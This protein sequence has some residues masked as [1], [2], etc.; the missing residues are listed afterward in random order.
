MQRSDFVHVDLRNSGPV[1]VLFNPLKFG[2]LISFY[3]AVLA[4]S[5]INYRALISGIAFLG[6]VGVVWRKVSIDFFAMRRALIISLSIVVIIATMRP[7]QLVYLSWYFVLLILLQ[8]GCGSVPIV[9]HGKWRRSRLMDFICTVHLLILIFS[10]FIYFTG[11][12][13]FINPNASAALI[14][15]LLLV[16]VLEHRE[17]SLFNK[18]SGL[19]IFTCYV[20]LV[21]QLSRSALIWVIGAYFLN[22]ALLLNK[23]KT[24]PRIGKIVAFLLITIVV[25]PVFMGNSFDDNAW[26]D[27]IINMPTWFR[28]KD[29]GLDSDVLRFVRYPLVL[30]GNIKS[31]GDLIFG[32][33]VGEK[34]YMDQLSE[35][36]DLHNAFLVIMSDGGFLL[37]FAVLI[38][39]FRQARDSE[40]LSLARVFIF[41]SGIVFSGVFL[42]LASFSLSVVL[43]IVA[44]RA[45]YL[46][47]V[48]RGHRATIG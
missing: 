17:R 40:Y 27:L 28:F 9:L 38:F 35:G 16:Y 36:E 47:G 24:L 29:G 11:S 37:L 42:G 12:E 46:K 43:L 30:S 1:G 44:A 14:G 4:N 19:M 33:G 18:S 25:M 10:S 3:Y 6:V 34:P 48:V 5:G 21:S 20:A 8:I 32:L 41:L 45:A 26:S 7:F 39:S 31:I 13:E 2:F 15:F 22:Q 23:N